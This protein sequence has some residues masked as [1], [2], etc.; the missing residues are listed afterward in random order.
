MKSAWAISTAIIANLAGLDFALGK[1]LSQDEPQQPYQQQ[2]I[3]GAYIVEFEDGQDVGAAISS[4]AR[5]SNVAGL[6]QRF[7]FDSTLFKGA[8]FNLE[9]SPGDREGDA[10][11]RFGALPEVKNIWPVEVVPTPKLNISW[12][13][14]GLATSLLQRRQV[15]A[16][17]YSPHVMTQ[18]DKLHEEGVTGKNFRI[19]IVDTGIDYTHPVLGGCFGPGCLVEFGADLVGEGY[20]GSQ[21]PNPDDDPFENCNGHGTHVAGI[22]AALENPLGFFG[23][24][25]GAKIGMYRAF[26]CADGTTMDALMAATVKAFEDGSD[27][28]TGSVGQSSGWADHPFAH[29]VSRIVAAGVPCTFAAGNEIGG[30]EGLFSVSSPSVGDGVLSVSSFENTY[31][32]TYDPNTGKASEVINTQTGGYI[33]SFTSWGPTFDLKVKPDVGAP[34]G[35]ILSTLPLA[36]GA[37]GVASGTSMACPLMASIVA[38][39]MEKRG[40]RDPALITRL[41]VRTA[42]P[43]HAFDIWTGRPIPYSQLGPVPQQGAGLVQAY[44]AAVSTVEIDAMR[45]SF[46]DTENALREAVVTVRNDGKTSVSYVLDHLPAMTAETI[47]SKSIYKQSSPTLSESYAKIV[48][49][50]NEL[51]LQPGEEAQISVS[52]TA[53]VDVDVSTLPIYSGWI[54][55]NETAGAAAPLVLPYVGAAG[56]MKNATVMASS[57]LWLTRSDNWLRPMLANDTIFQLPAPESNPEWGKEP[58][59]A[60]GSVLPVGA[61]PLQNIWLVMGSSEV[62]IQIQR[63]KPSC[64]IPGPSQSDNGFG[65]V[66]LGEIDAYPWTFL[67]VGSWDTI[68]DGLMADGS[69]VAPGRYRIIAYA[70]RTFGDRHNPGDWDKFVSTDFGIR[71]VKSG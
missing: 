41:L 58:L 7:Q 69:W 61:Y 19:G 24:A 27:I 5:R 36:M 59:E 50:P 40:T 63:V 29:L 60:T 21:P 30:T 12:T 49:T 11:Q 38:L 46:N 18:V 31:M 28:I 51:T 66:T 48:L 42:K 71:Y 55:L 10:L 34:G 23:A 70:L 16:G 3:P 53:P 47:W 44:D 67:R 56:A 13:G 2:Y 62:H 65:D 54:F 15:G 39:L 20:D 37:Y 6:T 45:L 33:S 9:L 43:G 64:S 14:E 68:W 17:G 8:S 32:P 22:I 25:P 26:S 52:V 35:N 57:R 1:K 4:L